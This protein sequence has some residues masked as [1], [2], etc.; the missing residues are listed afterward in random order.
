[1]DMN[2][3]DCLRSRRRRSSRR[4]N[5]RPRPGEKSSPSILPNE[6]EWK[7]FHA[8]WYRSSRKQDKESGPRLERAG[9]TTVEKMGTAGGLFDAVRPFPAKHPDLSRAGT[10]RPAH[11]PGVHA[12]M[13]TTAEHALRTDSSYQRS[14]RP[15][16]FPASASV[17]RSASRGYYFDP[18][19]AFFASRFSFKVLAACFLVSFFVS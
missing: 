7:G 6:R 11:R 17:A 1:M 8:V 5:E 13:D 14:V 2:E 9:T 15:A 10:R 19:L 12:H 16:C 4:K 3:K 18:F